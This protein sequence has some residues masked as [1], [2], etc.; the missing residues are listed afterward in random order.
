MRRARRLRRSAGTR[1]FDPTAC[2]WRPA[3]RGAPVRPRRRG[4]RG[5][6]GARP[7]RRGAHATRPA[8]F[9]AAGGGPCGGPVAKRSSATRS[10]SSRRTAR[11]APPGPARETGRERPVSGRQDFGSEW[12]EVAAGEGET[13]AARR[14]MAVPECRWR[15]R[16]EQPLGSLDIPESACNGRPSCGYSPA[17]GGCDPIAPEAPASA[18][19]WNT[20]WETCPGDLYRDADVVALRRVA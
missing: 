2:R 11:R 7:P 4:S 15:P 12:A 18:L 19:P 1:A 20:V 16:R 6:A 17:I 5:R 8:P 9:V 14:G 10:V 3:F 13:L